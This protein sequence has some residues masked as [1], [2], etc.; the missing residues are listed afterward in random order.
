M[1]KGGRRVTWAS[2]VLLLSSTPGCLVCCPL[3][4]V[5]AEPFGQTADDV[6]AIKDKSRRWEDAPDFVDGIR[7]RYR[8]Y[9]EDHPVLAALELP[10]AF[11]TDLAF[12]PLA[13]VAWGIHG[14]TS[15][16][17]SSNY[18]DPSPPPSPTPPSHLEPGD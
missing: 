16:S 2:I 18:Y 7:G 13:I 14:L 8:P 4:V 9:W 15:D 17:G 10:F 11:A 6:Y 5:S 12:L 1:G 3:A